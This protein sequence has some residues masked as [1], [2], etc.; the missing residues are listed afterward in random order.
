MF[1]HPPPPRGPI[2]TLAA[3]PGGPPDDATAELNPLEY[4][5]RELDLEPPRPV[6]PRRAGASP[7]SSSR[8]C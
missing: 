6:H 8:S 4:L 5:I 2:S 1:D 3:M 7:R